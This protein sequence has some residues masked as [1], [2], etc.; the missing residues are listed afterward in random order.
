MRTTN[1][2]DLYIDKTVKTNNDFGFEGEGQWAA[3]KETA[4]I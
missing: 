4:I 1:G 3:S 2:T